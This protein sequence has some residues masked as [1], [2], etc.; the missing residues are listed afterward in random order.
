MLSKINEDIF[1]SDSNS[2]SDKCLEK[3][4]TYK[5]DFSRLNEKKQELFY[6]Q[7][8]LKLGHKDLPNF[9]RVEQTLE[10]ISKIWEGRKRYE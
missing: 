1:L 7:T 6:Y 2:S 5:K 4:Q 9:F 3:L 10:W 8:Q